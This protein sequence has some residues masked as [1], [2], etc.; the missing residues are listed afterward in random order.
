MF[1]SLLTLTLVAASVFALPSAVPRQTTSQCDVFGPTFGNGGPYTLAAINRTDI[2]RNVSGTRLVFGPPIGTNNKNR[3][4]L[5]VSISSRAVLLERVLTG[6]LQTIDSYSNVEFP[7]VKLQ[8]GGLLGLETDGTTGAVDLDVDAGSPTVF[9]PTNIGA[10]K[11][12]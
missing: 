12:Y 4:S 7:T 2:G 11:V 3:R 5:A 6:I 10:A 9:A 8:D 1:A